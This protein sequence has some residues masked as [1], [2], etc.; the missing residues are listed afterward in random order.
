MSIQCDLQPWDVLDV[1]RDTHE[2]PL[3]IWPNA[4]SDSTHLFFSKAVLSSSAMGKFAIG[5]RGGAGRGN[6]SIGILVTSADFTDPFETEDRRGFN[7]LMLR[8]HGNC[9]DSEQ[10]IS[11]DGYEY[12]PYNKSP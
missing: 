4:P 2:P 8:E 7:P 3:P 6:R 9:S 12:D 11:E 5:N 1:I 10:S